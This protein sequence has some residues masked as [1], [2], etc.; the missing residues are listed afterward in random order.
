MPIPSLETTIHELKCRTKKMAYAL[1]H[2]VEKK[3]TKNTI[4]PQRKTRM[5]ICLLEDRLNPNG[6]DKDIDQAYDLPYDLLQQ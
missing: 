3:I 1:I 4:I 2:S 6:K 5:K